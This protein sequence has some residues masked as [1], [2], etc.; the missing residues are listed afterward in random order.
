MKKTIRI[1]TVA[2][3][4]LMLVGMAFPA[5]AGSYTTYTYSI[6]GYYLTSPD[7]YTPE[8]VYDSVDM[9]L[10]T[11]LGKPSDME[12]DADGNVYIA[13]PDNDRIVV[14]DRYLKFK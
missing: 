2:M 7:A 9:G 1:C 3:L 10:S 6:D 12:T 5:F 11:P 4:L 8:N 13:D 14:L